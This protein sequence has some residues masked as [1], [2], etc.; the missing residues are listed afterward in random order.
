MG[1]EIGATTLAV[2]LRRRHG[3]ATCEA[4][5]REAIADAADARRRRPAGRRR[6]AA[7]TPSASS[8][9]SSRSTSSTLEPHIN[10]P[11]TPDLARPRR[12]GRRRGRGARAGRSRSARALV[13]SCTNSSYEDI[14][15]AA[16]IARQAVGQGPA[17]QDRRCSSPPAPSRCGPPS[18]ATACWPTS[19]RSGPPCWPTPAVRASASGTAPTSTEGEV[20]IIVNSLQPQLPEAQRRQRQ[21]AGLRHLARDGRGARAGRH[22]RL[23]PAHRHAHQRRR[24]GGAARRAGRRGAARPG[25]RRR[26]RAASSAPPDGRLAASRSWSTRTATGSSCSS[27]SRRGTA[28]TTSSCRSC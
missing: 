12:R 8:T 13:G 7:P 4:T 25:L 28:R 27:P 24:R 6:G 2:R 23:R 1:A 22:A 11:H 9:R 20:N 18:S 17:G 16:S 26:A 5:G 3:A 21:H 19:R 15:R 10:G 14:T